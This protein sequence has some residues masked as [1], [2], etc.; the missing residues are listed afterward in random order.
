VR[1]IIK[2]IYYI[3][4]KTSE[5]MG[6]LTLNLA[7]GKG[8]TDFQPVLTSFL[9]LILIMGISNFIFVKKDF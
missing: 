3:I 1:G 8:I 7:S 4:P 2:V 9:F 5:L 6:Q